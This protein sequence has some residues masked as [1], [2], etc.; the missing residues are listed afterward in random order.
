MFSPYPVFFATL[1]M[2]LLTSCTFWLRSAASCLLCPAE[3]RALSTL[4][5]PCTPASASRADRSLIVATA[6]FLATSTDLVALASVEDDALA[7]M[8]LETQPEFCSRSTLPVPLRTFQVCVCPVT[9]SCPRFMNADV[10]F[11]PSI[12]WSKDMLPVCIF[13]IA[14][15]AERW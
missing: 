9:S 14:A 1:L 11:G 5:R 6:S 4:D 8:L 12:C 7:D 15:E 13:P 10:R 2:M 3:R